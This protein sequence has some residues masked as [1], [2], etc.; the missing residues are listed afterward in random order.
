ML[1]EV[2]VLKD[3]AD[4]SFLRCHVDAF[5]FVKQRLAVKADRAAIGLHQAGQEIHQGGLAAAGGAEDA[6]GMCF[7]P[8]FNAAEEGAESLFNVDLQQHGLIP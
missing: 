3:D 6:P 8:A 7:Q 2:G 5:V 4:T 1:E